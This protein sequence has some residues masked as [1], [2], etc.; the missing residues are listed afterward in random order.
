MTTRDTIVVGAGFAGMLGAL[1]LAD[2]GLRPLVLA[3]GQGTTHW[4]SGCID[5]WGEG[6]SPRAA[7]ESLAA[8]Q[9][10]HPYN[11]VGVA[12]VQAALERFMRLTREAGLPYAGSLDRNVLIPTA[13]G[14]LR[15][16]CLVPA[17]MAA[18]DMRIPGPLLVV[19]F[20]QLR[21]FYPPLI[22]AN[23]RAQGVEAHGV[24][25]DLPPSERTRDFGM[26]NT[27]LLFDDGELRRAVAS[28]VRELK[29]DATRVAFPALLGLNHAVACVREMQD[30]IGALVFEIA[31]LPPSVPGM[32]LSQ[33]M[34]RAVEAA[35]G[36]VQIG[37]EVLRGEPGSTGRLGAVFTE[38]AAREQ[39]HA[40]GRLLLATG[41]IAGGGLRADYGGGLREVAL[42]LPVAAPA[43]RAEW[44]HSKFMDQRGHPIYR[45]G[46]AVDRTL[47]A[48][49]R[50]GQVVYEN[51][52]VAGVTLAGAEPV[53]ER[54]YEGLAIATGFAAAQSLARDEGGAAVTQPRSLEMV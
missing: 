36:R 1:A 44:F 9:P 3:K 23:L 29:G 2:A 37:S 6:E 28:Q 22:A 10:A 35:G 38:A 20:H 30:I 54:C 27:A 12:G 5:V 53:R 41:G 13:S 50:E 14:A 17:T 52:R 15:P 46:I 24:Y 45:A 11:L 32:R 42:G 48:V 25:L 7:L 26:R 47:R 33:I 16:T 49:D 21:D 19:G 8:S 39:R 4:A 31:T 18:A 40:V 43:S 51:V 34:Q